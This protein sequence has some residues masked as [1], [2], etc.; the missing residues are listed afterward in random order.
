VKK[1][2]PLIT[3]TPYCYEVFTRLFDL[4]GHAYYRDVAASI[5]AFVS[6]DLRDTPT[7]SRAAAG[8]YTPFDGSKVVN[9]SAYR[10]FVLFDAAK[11][12]HNEAYRA[13]ASKNL[14]FIL[15]AQRPD[16]SWLYAIDSPAEA[17][18]DHFHTCFVLKN[19]FKL[20][21]DLRSD[22]VALAIRRGYEWYRRSLFDADDNPRSYAIAPRLQIVRIE[23]YNV[24]EAVSLGALLAHSIPEAFT[25]AETLAARFVHRGQ[26][27][28]GYWMT[29]LY[30]G[31]IRHRLPFLRWPQSQLFLALTNLLAVAQS[32]AGSKVRAVGGRAL[33]QPSLA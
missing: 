30:I 13:K 5:A 1:R 29:R 9:A 15:D 21:R 33:E 12:F 10:A 18:I 31:G 6:D 22:A 2:T 11:R 19:L 17:F 14:Q 32:T 24:A 20:N 28:A 26:L 4:T 3:A 16:G 8:S 23:M 27:P 7:A 25:I